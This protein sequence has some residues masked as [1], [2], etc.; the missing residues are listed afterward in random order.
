MQWLLTLSR[1]WTTSPIKRILSAILFLSMDKGSTHNKHFGLKCISSRQNFEKLR[2]RSAV[3][4]LQTNFWNY[5]NAYLLFFPL[6]MLNWTLKLC[7]R[8]QI[9]L[10]FQISNLF[11][12][13]ASL[14]DFLFAD[15][16]LN[17]RSGTWQCT[18]HIT[19]D[20]SVSTSCRTNKQTKK[21]FMQ[22]AKGIWLHTMT[23]LGKCIAGTHESFICKP[24]VENHYVIGIGEKGKC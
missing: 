22:M 3:F 19:V 10:T 20:S 17:V 16:F 14:L 11:F 24:P 5:M 7:R 8:I 21:S 2:F 4:S 23:D 9:K 18:S 15:K 6:H 1:P 13:A 12:F